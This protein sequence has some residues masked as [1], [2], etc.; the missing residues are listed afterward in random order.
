MNPL[1]QLIQDWVDSDKSHSVGLLASRGGIS[2][3]TI[4]AIL[5]REDPAGLPRRETL[6]ALAKGMGSPL[7]VL[8]EA[9]AKA[10]GFRVDTELDPESQE[11]QAWLALL[12]DLPEERRTE[13]WEIGRMYLRRAKEEP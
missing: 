10:A 1:Q 3:N 6:R 4:Y 11:I 5:Q 13:L 12:D 7:R 2:R 9:A 8:E